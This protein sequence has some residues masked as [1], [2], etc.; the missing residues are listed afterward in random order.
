MLEEFQWDSLPYQPS[1]YPASVEAAQCLAHARNGTHDVAFSKL[2]DVQVGVGSAA[3][4][5]RH[6]SKPQEHD[7]NISRSHLSTSSSHSLTLTTVQGLGRIA[8]TT[9]AAPVAFTLGMTQGFRNAPALYA[10]TT[11]NGWDRMAECDQDR[12]LKVRAW[13]V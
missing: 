4:Y 5:E 8:E 10:D 1:N 9:C 7:S 13:N 12:C 6:P 3:L 11:G 2:R